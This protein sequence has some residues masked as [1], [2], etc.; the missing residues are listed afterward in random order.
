MV[1]NK[2]LKMKFK[3]IMAFT[4]L[5]HSA[6]AQLDYKQFSGK[7]GTI[8]F[9]KQYSYANLYDYKVNTSKED[10]IISRN[11]S[12]SIPEGLLTNKYTSDLLK[13]TKDS[14]S[15]EIIMYSRLVVEVN[16]S[17]VCLIKYRTRNNGALAE[18]QILPAVRNGN[19]WQELTSLSTEIQYLSQILLYLNPDLIFQ[20]YN[21]RDDS[22]YEELN[23]LKPSIKNDDGSIDVKKLAQVI[24]ENQT[25]LQQYL[26][27]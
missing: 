19:V 16:G 10:S 4:F 12:I 24:K 20:F 23:K 26:D 27:E 7:S 11:L 6:F 2:Q 21:R 15:F 18:T 3:L 13:N 14:I 1:I 5:I 17:R 9:N 25:Q 22:D 8:T